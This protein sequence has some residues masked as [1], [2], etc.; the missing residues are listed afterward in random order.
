MIPCSFAN[1]L[2]KLT[3]NK[4]IKGGYAFLALCYN[5]RGIAERAL[6][7]LYEIRRPDELKSQEVMDS[8]K[9]G[10]Q[11]QRLEEIPFGFPG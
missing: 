4:V 11:R 10:Y 7:L 8:D 6:S 1:I 5:I 3:E 2:D 9:A